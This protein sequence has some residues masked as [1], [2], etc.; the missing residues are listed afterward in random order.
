MEHNNFRNFSG[1]ELQVMENSRPVID[2]SYVEM[3]ARLTCRIIN[4]SNILGAIAFLAMIAAPGAVES[5]MYI[6][7]VVLVAIFAVC[8]HLSIREDGKRK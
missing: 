8:A 1:E 5:E 6:T 3:P 4:L 2:I 7:A